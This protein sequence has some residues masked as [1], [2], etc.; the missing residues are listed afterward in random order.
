[1]CHV[2][3]GEFEKVTRQTNC[4]TGLQKAL[5]HGVFSPP[6]SPSRQWRVVRVILS[7]GHI[8]SPAPSHH[9]T[10]REPGRQVICL[11]LSTPHGV[12]RHAFY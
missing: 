2:R 3:R 7:H 1:M 6:L 9:Q 11:P 8:G 12:P 10:Q 4:V 5:L